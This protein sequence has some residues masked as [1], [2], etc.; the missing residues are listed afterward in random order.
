M[1]HNVI[2][3]LSTGDDIMPTILPGLL[4]PFLGTTLGAACVFFIK[5]E[6]KAAVQKSLLGFASG[7]MVAMPRARVSA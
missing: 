2:N 6:L 3:R 1:H 7:V 5:N 4:L